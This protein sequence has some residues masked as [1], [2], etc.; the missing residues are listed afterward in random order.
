MLHRI[1]YLILMP[2]FKLLFRFQVEG[3]ENIPRESFILAANHM[4]YLDP[5]VLGLAVYPRKIYFMA[6]AELFKIPLFSWLIS[7]LYAFPVKRGAF[8]RQAIELACL[9]LQKG[10]IVG[11]F[12]EGTRYRRNSLGRPQAGVGLLV[13][14]TGVPVLP[15]GIVGTDKVLPA[16]K[17]GLRFPQIKAVIGNP[18]Y[19]LARDVVSERQRK[20]AS[21]I[22]KRIMIEISQLSGKELSLKE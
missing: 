18:I 21:E 13:I 11:M 4:S 10:K 15:V 20:K 9:Y 3:K 5:I 8:D 6:K 7:K 1:A 12:P 17:F 14:K 16:G 2:L 19:N 22:T